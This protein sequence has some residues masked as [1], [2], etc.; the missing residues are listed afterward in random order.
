[1]PTDWK[2]LAKETVH[3]FDADEV[4]GMWDVDFRRATQGLP[5]RPRGRDRRRE[6]PVEEGPPQDERGRLRPR[7][8]ARAAA[9]AR[10][11][12]RAPPRR[13]S[14]S[15]RAS[16]AILARPGLVGHSS[17]SSSRSSR[18]RSCSRWSSSTSSTS[19][20]SSSWRAT[21]RRSSCPRVLPEIGAFEL[22]AFNRDREHGRGRPLRLRAAPGRAPR[23]P[24]RR[25]LGPRDGRGARHGGHAR[26]LPDAA[27]AS[28]R[29]PPR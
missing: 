6:A 26:G 24:L 3:S 11:R 28:I 1:M 16:A 23:G 14:P 19:R 5:R 12:R 21:S 4:R 29:P 18:S 25:R 17:R 15:S 7:E 2:S 22:G 10:V 13:F 27:S 9:P 8:A 20:T